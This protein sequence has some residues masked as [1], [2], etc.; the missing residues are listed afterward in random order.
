MTKMKNDLQE[1]LERIRV[2]KYPDLDPA[3]VASIAEVQADYMESQSDAYRR[4]KQVIETYLQNEGT[5]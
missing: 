3:L 5:T 2:E 4:I 1:T